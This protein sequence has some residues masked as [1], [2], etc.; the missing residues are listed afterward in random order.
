[1]E[2]KGR[3]AEQK[4]NYT[5]IFSRPLSMLSRVQK[6]FEYLKRFYVFLTNSID[7]KEFLIFVNRPMWHMKTITQNVCDPRVAYIIKNCVATIFLNKTWFHGFRLSVHLG[8]VYILSA[9]IAQ[10]MVIGE[11][12][13]RFWYNQEPTGATLPLSPKTLGIFWECPSLPTRATLFET[14]IG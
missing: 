9:Y 1:M 10:D 13:M 8:K 12:R 5:N 14:W 3:K 6:I 11:V 4:Q 2:L 7:W